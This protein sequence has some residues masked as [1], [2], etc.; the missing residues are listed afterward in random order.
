MA[1]EIELSPEVDALRKELMAAGF[2]LL[3]VRYS[4]SFGNRLISLTDNRI[5]IRFVRD[6]GVWNVELAVGRC[7]TTKDWL[8]IPTWARLVGWDE[9]QADGLLDVEDQIAFVRENLDLIHA[10]VSKDRL[11]ETL[12]VLSRLEAARG[13]RTMRRLSGSG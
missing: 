11:P 8:Y 9:M 6:R 1:V 4:N 10:A 2:V 7:P 5:A 3:E 12:D 13:K